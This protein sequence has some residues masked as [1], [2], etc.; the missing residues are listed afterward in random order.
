LIDPLGI[1]DGFDLRPV[2]AR[3]SHGGTCQ[4]GIRRIG[5]STRNSGLLRHEKAGCDYKKSSEP[6]DHFVSCFLLLRG[7][8]QQSLVNQ[9]GAFLKALNADPLI[10]A[11]R[12]CKIIRADGIR[13]DP[14]NRNVAAPL[15][16]SV[17]T[18]LE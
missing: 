13:I 14:V 10:V 18:G 6:G 9:I 5:E 7:N 17:S 8:L 11:V 4:R 15:G 16:S 3:N 1:G 2:F 12:A